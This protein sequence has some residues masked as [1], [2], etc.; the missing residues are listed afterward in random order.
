MELTYHR[1]GEYLFPNLTVQ[2]EPVQLGKYGMLRRT[3]LKENKQNWYQSMLLTG[4]LN[5]HLLEIEKAAEDRMDVLMAGLLKTV[6][7]PDKEKDQLAWTAHMNSLQAMGRGDHTDGI[8]VQLIPETTEQ[9]LSE[10]EEEIASALSLPELPTVERQRRV[11][12]ERQAA[13]YAGEDCHS[14]SR[15][16]RSAAQ[17]RQSGQKPAPA[18][19]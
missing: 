4:K 13:L 7:G 14:R 19:L 11:I 12:E 9:D 17:W 6:P 5:R 8:G 2:E 1:K 16:G 10:A 18:D 15:G 3:Y